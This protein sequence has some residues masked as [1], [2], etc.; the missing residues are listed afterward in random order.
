M[1]I[2]NITIVVCG[3]WIWLE[4]DTKPVKEQ[5]KTVDTGATMK[6]GFSHKKKQWYFS[7]EGYR[8]WGNREL[9]FEEIKNRYGYNAKESEKRK[10]VAQRN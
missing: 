10:Q 4:G 1:A 7:P 9:S 8:K 2:P 3:S 6:R 5:I